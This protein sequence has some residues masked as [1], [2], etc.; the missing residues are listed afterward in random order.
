M[1]LSPATLADPKV[2][3]VLRRWGVDVSAFDHKALP[4]I[5]DAADAAEIEARKSE[6]RAI[7]AEDSV[8]DTQTVKRRIRVGG[9]P[10]CG[11]REAYDGVRCGRCGYPHPVKEGLIVSEPGEVT[12]TKTGPPCPTC[13]RPTH[14]YNHRCYVCRP[15][16]PPRGTKL[17]PRKPGEA[18]PQL[19]ATVVATPTVDV[20][21]YRPAVER[22]ACSPLVAADTG[23][24]EADVLVECL[25]RISLLPEDAA[26]RVV[27]Y[28]HNRWGV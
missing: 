20:A 19:P 13:R 2:R 14:V 4:V 17:G 26:R 23:D 15:G 27:G 16:G 10:A 9:C 21:S 11:R 28:L 22:L 25:R 12:S 18:A 8:P 7:K 24:P 3:D 5:P 6:L 1:M